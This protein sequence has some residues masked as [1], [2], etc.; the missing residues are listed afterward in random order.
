M[1]AYLAAYQE[2]PEVSVDYVYFPPERD[3]SWAYA[4]SIDWL[5]E[6]EIQ[7]CERINQDLYAFL[8]AYTMAS[9]VD[10]GWEPEVVWT[11]VGSIDGEYRIITNSR[12]IPAALQDGFVEA[13]YMNPSEIDPENVVDA[14]DVFAV[15][16]AP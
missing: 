11:Y 3:N 14:E 16:M 13:N 2:G 12:N 4:E 6:Y 8:I 5:V 9:T 7:E 1:E 15:E 10:M